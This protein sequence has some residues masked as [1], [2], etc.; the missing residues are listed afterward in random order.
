[1]ICWNICWNSV[2]IGI[3]VFLLSHWPIRGQRDMTNYLWSSRNN[4]H[5]SERVA[6][7]AFSHE[8]AHSFGSPHDSGACLGGGESGHY[9]MHET[10]SLGLQ[11]NNYKLSDCSRGNMSQVVSTRHCW[12]VDTSR[13]GRNKTRF[14]LPGLWLVSCHQ[15][16]DLIGWYSW[17]QK[18][19]RFKDPL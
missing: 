17:V 16:S 12:T 11:L 4:L 8:I 2:L 7:L 5:V 6:T 13:Q 3:V 14:Q 19:Q 1:M 15:C 10:G 9:L 18:T